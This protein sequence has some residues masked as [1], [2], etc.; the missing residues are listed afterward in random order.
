MNRERAKELL[1]IIQAF[2]EG[3]GIQ[4]RNKL[5]DWLDVNQPSWVEHQEYRIKPEPKYMWLITFKD[6][7]G[8]W[9]LC[10]SHFTSEENAVTYASHYKTHKI[11]KILLED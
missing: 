9:C 2:A 10:M 3:K 8:N 1:P 5:T 11:H 6:I 4:T 7:N